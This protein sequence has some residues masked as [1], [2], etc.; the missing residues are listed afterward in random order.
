MESVAHD[1]LFV[2]NEVEKIEGRG[3][4]TSKPNR[5]QSAPASKRCQELGE[6]R[7]TDG[8]HRDV[9]TSSVGEFA[10]GGIDIV[11]LPVNDV[12]GASGDSLLG[13]TGRGHNGDRD[14]TQRPC[15]L[16]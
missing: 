16:Y 4:S 14:A 1:L 12:L 13:T 8:I 2:A 9:H 15:S 6:Q 11:S 7:P 3:H 5:N 10:D